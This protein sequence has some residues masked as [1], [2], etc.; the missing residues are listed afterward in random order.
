MIVHSTTSSPFLICIS[1]K[2]A[3]NPENH[4]FFNGAGRKNENFTLSAGYYPV[5][6]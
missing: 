5:P 1:D 6:T 3:A 4:A 2:T